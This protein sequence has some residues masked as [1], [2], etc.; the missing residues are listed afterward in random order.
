MILDR[1][2]L[3][4]MFLHQSF[5]AQTMI[6]DPVNPLRSAYGASFLAAYR[7]STHLLKT[8]QEQFELCP[9]LCA[10]F[11][12]TWTFSF[13]AAV[14]VVSSLQRKLLI[15]IN[16]CVRVVSLFVGRWLRGGRARNM[17]RAR[18]SILTRHASCSRRRLHIVGELR[19]RWYVFVA[20]SFTVKCLMIYG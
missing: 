7:C 19:R 10:R 8:I 2:C 13:S 1:A 15:S 14:R 5:F 11:W 6:D 4:L 20:A 3:V 16:L 18:C 17:R 12:V 9:E